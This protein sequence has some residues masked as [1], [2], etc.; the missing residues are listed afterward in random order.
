MLMAA[1]EHMGYL[2]EVTFWVIAQDTHKRPDIHHR[3]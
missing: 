2:L 3:S 1:E